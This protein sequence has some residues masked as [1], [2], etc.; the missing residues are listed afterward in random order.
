LDAGV[1]RVQA[2]ESE[3]LRRTEAAT[4]RARAV[5]V[6][7]VMREDAVQESCA[8]LGGQLPRRWSDDR[9]PARGGSEDLGPERAM[10]D[11]ATL[12]GDREFG[13]VAD[14]PRLADVVQQGCRH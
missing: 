10:P 8:A 12:L 13:A 3:R 1:E 7:P 4:A 6:G 14:L 5:P 2:V 9:S 11:Q